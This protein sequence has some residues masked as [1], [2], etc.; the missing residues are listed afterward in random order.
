MPYCHLRVYHGPETASSEPW[1]SE[2]SGGKRCVTLPVGEVLPLLADA[3]RSGRS[4]LDD[5][6]DD[7]MT[8]STDLYELLL[9]Y[10]HFRRPSA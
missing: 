9:A 1:E 3:A 6:S 10:Q 7:E 5:F 8:I 2:P 4:W